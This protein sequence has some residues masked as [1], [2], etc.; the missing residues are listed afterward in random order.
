MPSPV[1]RVPR[2]FGQLGSLFLG[3]PSGAWHPWGHRRQHLLLLPPQLIPSCLA[4]ARAFGAWEALCRGGRWYVLRRGTAGRPQGQGVGLGPQ[5]LPVKVP[6]GAGPATQGACTLLRDATL[7][8]ER[9]STGEEIGSAQRDE[10]G[11]AR[12]S[13]QTLSLQWPESCF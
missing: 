6:P 12:L 2:R 1:P 8:E 4:L 5:G 13:L 9:K 7:R 11:M 10:S 3:S